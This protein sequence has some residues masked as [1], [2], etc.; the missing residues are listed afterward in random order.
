MCDRM[1]MYNIKEVAVLQ[2][3][4]TV[5]NQIVHL[6]MANYAE[7]MKC[8]NCQ[9]VREERWDI[10]LILKRI[11]YFS[12]LLHSVVQWVLQVMLPSACSFIAAG[13]RRRQ[14]NLQNPL[15]R[16]LEH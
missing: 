2:Y 11:L 6:K 3:R 14:H 5:Q 1:Q 15:K 8:T 16:I 10:S 7:R 4:P 13:R 12:I 9:I